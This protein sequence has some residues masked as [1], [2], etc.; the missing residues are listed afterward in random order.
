MLETILNILFIIS[1]VALIVLEAFVMVD[2][3]G[4]AACAAEC[5]AECEEHEDVKLELEK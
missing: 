4:Y 3:A 2:I 5:A 1:F